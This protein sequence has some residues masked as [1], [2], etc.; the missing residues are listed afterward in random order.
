M[1]LPS[2]KSLKREGKRPRIPRTKEDAKSSFR[3]TMF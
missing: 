3:E 1:M 2:S